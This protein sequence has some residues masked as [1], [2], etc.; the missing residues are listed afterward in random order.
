MVATFVSMVSSSRLGRLIDRRGERGT[1][2]IV[3]LFYVFALVG[4]ALA[5]NAWLASFF[6]V[7]YSVITPLSTIGGS[8]YL[9]KIAV[10]EDVASS[11]AMGITIL[12]AT[13]I[14]GP[15]RG[16][17]HPQIHRLP[18]AVLHRLRVRAH[19][20]RGHAAARSGEAAV[21]SADSGRRGSG[22]RQVGR[23]VWTGEAPEVAPQADR[24]LVLPI[25]LGRL[26]AMHEGAGWRPSVLLSICSGRGRIRSG[27]P[28]LCRPYLDLHE[29]P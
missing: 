15:G 5:G 24:P 1:L 27:I 9:R 28:L 16:R 12:H 26:P 20:L 14:V 18:G 4:F 7:I 8:T 17:V 11:L 19:Q 25:V 6:Y 23:R 10:H 22:R 2:S 13:A 29:R 21:R 3:N